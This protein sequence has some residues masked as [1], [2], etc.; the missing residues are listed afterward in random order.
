MT[1]SHC[2]ASTEACNVRWLMSGRRC[3]DSCTH[4]PPDEPEAT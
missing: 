3:C 2:Q 4:R 1:C